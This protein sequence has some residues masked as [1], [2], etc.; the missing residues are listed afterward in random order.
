MKDAFSGAPFFGVF[1][2]TADS[3]TI[4]LT[5]VSGDTLIYGTDGQGITFSPL[6]Y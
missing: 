5:H 6:V 3:G 1:T 2:V 4:T